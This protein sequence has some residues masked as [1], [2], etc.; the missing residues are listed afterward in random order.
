[1]YTKWKK[2]KKTCGKVLT[3]GERGDIMYK[4]SA[5]KP[6]ASRKESKSFLK[7]LSKK[8]WQE[9]GYVIYSLSCLRKRVAIGPWK[10]NNEIR[11]GTRDFD[12]KKPSEE[13]L[14]VLFKQ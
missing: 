11:K 1:M 9:R 12:G 5:G 13:F 7:K 6:E 8:Y 10:L 14:K 2:K 4:L 3:K